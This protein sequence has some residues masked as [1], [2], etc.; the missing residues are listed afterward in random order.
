MWIKSVNKDYFRSHMIHELCNIKRIS[1]KEAEE[2]FN[3]MF[4]GDLDDLAFREEIFNKI[5][6]LKR[7]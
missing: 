4:P 1:T 3:E 2:K 6:D 7:R 5:E